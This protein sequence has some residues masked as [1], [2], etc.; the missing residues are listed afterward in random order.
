MFLREPRLPKNHRNHPSGH[1]TA[2]TNRSNYEVGDS[3]EYQAR[4][5][6]VDNFAPRI[7]LLRVRKNF[8][9]MTNH[10]S[11]PGLRPCQLDPRSAN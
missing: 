6:A 9:P 3:S 1:R 7:F 4:N 8:A 5:I 10:E 11:A 2:M